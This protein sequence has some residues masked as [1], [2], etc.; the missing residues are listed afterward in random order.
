MIE[1]NK[2][3][4][5]FKS[6]FKNVGGNEG[7]KC[8]YTM[9]LDTYGCGCQHNCKYCY[10]KS[11][12]DFRKLWD[13]AHPSIVNIQKVHR[14]ILRN[15]HEGDIV[16]LGGMTD[17]FQPLEKKARA[18]YHTIE[19]LNKQNIGYLIVTKSAMIADNEYIALMRK[20]LA[21]I[22]VTITCTDDKFSRTYE[23]ASVPS[24][25]IKAVEKL[26]RA[27]FDVQVRLSPFI[28]QFISKG[29]LN[30]DIINHIDCDK[31]IVE[32]LRVNSWIKKWF[33]IDYSEYTIKQSNYL[34]LPLDKKQK[35]IK[36][37]NGFE[38]GG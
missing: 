18:T 27:G 1:I 25:R 21:H 32:F 36:L 31:I 15:L 23:A 30:M 7:S 20:D 26:Q 4:K 29:V 12:L 28:P 11:L 24:E 13:P 34:H 38:G 9:R 17:C 3:N 8:H 35:Y 5:E 37:I 6:F 10:A 2:T 22:Q 19:E 33:D 14:T 16:R